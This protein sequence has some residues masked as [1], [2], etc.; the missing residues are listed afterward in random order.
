MVR[1]AEDGPLVDW[2][3]GL[4]PAIPVPLDAVVAGRDLVNPQF[5]PQTETDVGFSG[6]G[7]TPHVSLGRKPLVKC[8]FQV[9]SR[10]ARDPID[11][12]RRGCGG[13]GE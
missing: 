10:T 11:R 1:P 4:P 2:P 6:V 12:G 5:L 8:H 3:V 13:E 9:V 7:V